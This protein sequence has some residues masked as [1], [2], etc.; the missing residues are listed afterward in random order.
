MTKKMSP[1]IKSVAVTGAAGLIGSAVCRSLLARGVKVIAIDNFSIGSWNQEGADITWEKSNIAHP[2]VREALDRHL[3]D[4]VVHCAAHPGGKSND[5]PIE[6]VEVN[7]LGSMRIFQWCAESKTPVVFLS[8]SAVYGDQPQGPINESAEA[9]P[10]KIYAIC[11]IACER[12]LKTL[13]EH[14]GL[15]W[16]VLRV[17]ATYGAGHKPSTFQGVVNVMLTQLMQGERVVSKGLLSRERDLIYVNDTA[18]A[19]V[20]AVFTDKARGRIINVGSGVASD[21]SSIIG[22]C[23][24][25]LGKN[26]D[27][28]KIVEEPGLVGDPLY[29][30]ADITLARELLNFKP[31][32][33]LEQGLSEL[34]QRRSQAA[35]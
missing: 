4:A 21:I 22:A 8:S 24:K 34:M 16:T 15:K 35:A 13:G 17:F 7:A 29:S 3:P 20:S 33:T 31:K 30:V 26:P 32:F 1:A 23:A 25:A 28:I 10:G 18:E 19:I 2:E 11:K 14:Y 12:F 5:E 27:A 9:H 6:D